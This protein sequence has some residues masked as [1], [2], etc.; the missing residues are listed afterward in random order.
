MPGNFCNECGHDNPI[1]ARFCASCGHQLQMVEDLHT[2]GFDPVHVGE[3][4]SSGPHGVEGELVVTAGHRA[5]TRCGFSGDLVTV[6][7]HP[8][9]DVFLDDITVSRR[10]V[11]LARTPT[12]YLARDTGSLNGTYV[13]G[14]RIDGELPLTNGDELQVGKFKML[15][16]MTSMGA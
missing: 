7:R 6:G 10:H 13:N 12:G 1:G 3:A 2:E 11:E 9:S 14:E 16:L 4:D 15:Y 5:G 8:K